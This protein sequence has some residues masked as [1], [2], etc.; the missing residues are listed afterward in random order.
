MLF[1]H[2]PWTAWEIEV[3]T[4]EEDNCLPED[5]FEGIYRSTTR[6][7]RK[8]EQFTLL[9]KF[10]SEC[11]LQIRIYKNGD[12]TIESHPSTFTR[13]DRKKKRITVTCAAR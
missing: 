6:E 4:F 11:L 10:G 12:I 1:D 3:V 7:G 5:T 9:E 8:C 2:R 13:I